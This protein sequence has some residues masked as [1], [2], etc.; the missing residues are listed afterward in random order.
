VI[1][2]DAPDAPPDREPGGEPTA[3]LSGELRVKRLRWLARRGMRELE[4]LIEN[5]LRR[6]AAA[7][8]DGAWPELEALL[9][10]ED[11][12]LWAWFQGRYDAAAE[13]YRSLLDN[14]RG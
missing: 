6:E 14:L 8:S 2:A 12:Q 3:A 4:I 11:D 7:L 10:C 1:G 9:A 13:P 5:F